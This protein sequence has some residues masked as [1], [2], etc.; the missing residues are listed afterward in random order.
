[1]ALLR[2]YS[3]DIYTILTKQWYFK[4]YTTVC[5]ARPDLMKSFNFLL[6]LIG[7]NYEGTGVVLSLTLPLIITS[8]TD[9]CSSFRYS[10]NEEKVETCH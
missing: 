9:D 8:V 1:M 10:T 3:I 5:I 6:S 2:Q 7:G 4:Y